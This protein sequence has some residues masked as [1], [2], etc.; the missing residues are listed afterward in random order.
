V[1]SPRAVSQKGRKVIESQ[2]K[3]F[4][5]HERRSRLR[6]EGKLPSRAPPPSP[7]RRIAL[8]W[9]DEVHEPKRL[10]AGP[11]GYNGARFDE[12]LG[13][14]VFRA[15]MHLHPP[16]DCG[17]RVPEGGVVLDRRMWSSLEYGPLDYLFGIDC[18][19]SMRFTICGKSERL[20]IGRFA[21]PK[22]EVMIVREG[23]RFEY[24]IDG[25]HLLTFYKSDCPVFLWPFANGTTVEF[26]NSET[27]V[28]TRDGIA[29]EDEEEDVF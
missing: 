19:G 17:R 28:P 27:M 24:H 1:L 9:V 5:V 10:R 14:F 18:T 21:K 16:R 15:E 22:M 29:P 20:T 25:I 23:C 11:G 7:T 6:K 13:D 8:T 4:D 2:L 12:W 26:S 3:W